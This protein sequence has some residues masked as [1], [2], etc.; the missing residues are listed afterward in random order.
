MKKIGV[1]VGSLRKAAWSKKL[2]NY[3]VGLLPEGYEAEFIEIGNLPH[4]N[5]EYDE[6]EAPESYVKY[7]GKMHEM[8]AFIIVTPEYN[9][10]M[11]AVL[12]N[13]LDVG[14]RPY[15]KSAWDG[16]KAMILSNS[17]GALGGFGA[18][19]HLRQAFT[20]LN[21]LVMA[22]PEAYISRVSELFDDN[23]EL[24]S[25]GTGKFLQSLIDAFVAFVEE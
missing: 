20:F 24:K 13:A 25:E 10:S 4:Y 6:G 22:Q 9:R 7:R 12:K 15:G 3:L 18:N 14:S 23:G 8:D 16:K 11:P 1:L 17:P 19:H 5:Q 2:A 21:V